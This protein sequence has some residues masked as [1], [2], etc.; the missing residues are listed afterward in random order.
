MKALFSL[1]LT[2]SFA[3]A[4]LAL[5]PLAGVPVQVAKRHQLFIDDKT[6]MNEAVFASSVQ[7]LGQK[8][9]LVTINC[10]MGAY[11]GTDKLYILSEIGGTTTVTDVIILESIGGAVLGTS[12]IGSSEYDE[13]TKTLTSTA[14]GRG[15]GDCGRSSVSKLIESEYGTI[16]FKTIEIRSKDKCDGGNKKWPVVFK[17]K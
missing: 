5:D 10:I 7:D 12:D 17:Q 6:C 16:N 11:Q 13:K 3:H 4:A 2:F 8:N 1:I 15:L 9:K 14:K